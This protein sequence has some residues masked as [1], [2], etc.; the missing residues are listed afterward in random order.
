MSKGNVFAK[1]I[2]ISLYFSCTYIQVLM[3]G[4]D[5]DAKKAE[6]W[7]NKFKSLTDHEQITPL[8]PSPEDSSSD[9]KFKN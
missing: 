9:R 2:V 3:H 6:S 4:M 7:W 8:P 1:L 5:R